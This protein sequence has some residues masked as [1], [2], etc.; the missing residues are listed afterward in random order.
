MDQNLI[1]DVEKKREF[2]KLPNSLVERALI[3]SKKDVKQT[4]AFLRKFFGVF[5]TNK[6]LKLK[7]EEVLGTHISSKNRNYNEFYRLLFKEESKFERVIDLGCGVNG[8]SYPLLEKRFGNLEYIGIEAIGQLVEKM[9]TFFRQ[10]CFKNARAVCLDLFDLVSL[11]KI[12]PKTKT[13]QAIFL[14]QVIDALEGFEKNF[15]KKLLIFLNE[16]VSSKDVIFISMSMKSIS[17]KTKFESK[18]RWLRLFLEENFKV[19]EFFI[20]SERIFECR[21]K[22]VLV[23]NRSII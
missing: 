23:E 13:L 10:R 14:F 7:D 9:N 1:S 20:G 4:R 22:I 3:L 21:K 18:R 8:F 17:G 19:K 6:V 11:K 5:M 12:F 16:N 2:S 15:S